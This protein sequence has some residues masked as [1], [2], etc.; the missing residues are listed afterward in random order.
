MPPVL[1]TPMAAA[2]KV[3]TVSSKGW[4]LENWSFGPVRKG[5]AKI[6]WS[7]ST[8]IGNYAERLRSVSRSA[9]QLFPFLF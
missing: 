9:T 8:L 4:G 3:L 1:G 2:G 5:L 7:A 6:F